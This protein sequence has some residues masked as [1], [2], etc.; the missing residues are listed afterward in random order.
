MVL[1]ASAAFIGGLKFQGLVTLNHLD[2]YV[3]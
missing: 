1:S 3:P 2:T